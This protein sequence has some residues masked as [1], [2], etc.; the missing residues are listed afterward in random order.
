MSLKLHWA[1]FLLFVETGILEFPDKSD[2]YYDE[3]IKVKTFF[4]KPLSRIRHFWFIQMADKAYC[5]KSVVSNPWDTR[6]TSRYKYLQA[7]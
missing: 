4:C 7:T 3:D 5:T 2:Q 6:V 1:H